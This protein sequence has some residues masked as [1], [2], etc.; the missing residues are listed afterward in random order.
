MYPCGKGHPH[1]TAEG[2]TRCNSKYADK[3][4]KRIV[5]RGPPIYKKIKYDPPITVDKGGIPVV[6]YY[7]AVRVA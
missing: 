5:D 6:M 4:I 7:S 1:N 2:M 3:R